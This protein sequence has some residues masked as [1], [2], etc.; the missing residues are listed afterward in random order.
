MEKTAFKITLGQKVVFIQEPKND[1][2][3]SA[4]KLTGMQASEDNKIH[5]MYKMQRNLIQNILLEIDGKKYDR[6]PLEEVLSLKEVGALQKII[7]DIT[8]MGNEIV[9]VIETVIL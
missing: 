8:G 5:Y 1:H 3:E 9:P 6:Q 7:A 4:M 2:I